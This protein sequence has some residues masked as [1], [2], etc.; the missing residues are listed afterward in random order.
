MNA[1]HFLLDRIRGLAVSFDVSQAA[2][3]DGIASRDLVVPATNV[4]R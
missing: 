4:H 2:P 1:K 3:V